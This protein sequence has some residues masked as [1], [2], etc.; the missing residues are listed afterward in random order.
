MMFYLPAS[1]MVP[2]TPNSWR[3]LGA[4]E[5]ADCTG[6]GFGQKSRVW[7]FHD[8]IMIAG[9]RVLLDR[10]AAQSLPACPGPGSTKPG[11]GCRCAKEHYAFGVDL[12]AGRI[13]QHSAQMYIQHRLQ[14]L[15]GSF[16]KRDAQNLRL[17]VE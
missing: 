3:S 13:A 1:M 12:A 6:E 10:S 9:D 17:A 7:K 14:A 5:I 2:E 8:G 16:V 11:L 15:A 4:S